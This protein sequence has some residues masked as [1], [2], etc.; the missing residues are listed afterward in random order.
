ML[1]IWQYL[2]LNTVGSNTHGTMFNCS[3]SQMGSKTNDRNKAFTFDDYIF[4]LLNYCLILNT[5]TYSHVTTKRTWVWLQL[6]LFLFLHHH[7]HLQHISH[8][9]LI[10]YHGC[11]FLHLLLCPAFLMPAGMYLYTNLGMWLLFI[12]NATVLSP[13]CGEVACIC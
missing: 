8:T 4:V 9:G 5:N 2:S 11:S 7:H 12:L 6:I 1:N 10:H 3:I 13:P